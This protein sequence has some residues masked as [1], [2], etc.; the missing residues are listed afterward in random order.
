[1]TETGAEG[2][3]WDLSDLYLSLDD[4]RTELDQM[5]ELASKFGE[6]YRGKIGDSDA[7]GLAFM[8]IELEKIHDRLGRLYTYAYL[9]WSTNTGDTE[10]GAFLQ[11]V[12]EHY[13]R[14][15]Q[16]LL[17]VDIEWGE[18]ESAKAFDLLADP[19]LERFAHYLE[20]VQKQKA[21]QLSEAE[22]RVIAELS[23]NGRSAWNRYFDETL[24]AARFD[25]DGKMLSQQEVLSKLHESDRSLRERA[26]EAFTKGLK[27]D[28]RSLAY[29]FNTILA[30]KASADR[31]RNY[32]SWLSSRNA[33]NEVDDSN[34]EA[35]IKAVTDRYDISIRYY[36]LKSKVLG[37]DKMKDFDRYAPI[38]E[39][40]SKISWREARETV[41]EAYGEFHPELGSIVEE[42]FRENWIDA[43]VV[44]GKR[45]GAFSHGAVPS[46]HPYI[47]MNY[48]GRPRD[49][50]TLA[51][52][53]GHGVHQYLSR[54]QGVFHA[55]T[56]LTTAET[57]S[58]FGE[59]L[60][61][62]SLL[63]KEND[64]KNR[65]AML[66]GKID[67]SM[68]TVFRQV[69]M[70]RFENEVHTARREK[71]ELNPTQ[72][73]DMWMSTQKAMFAD[74]VELTENYRHW[75]S[76][77]PH[78]LHTPG[79]VYAYAFGELLVFGL[80]ERYLKSDGD[81]ENKYVELLSAGGSDYPHELLKPFEVDLKDP[82]FWKE[83]LNAIETWVTEAE[84]LA[85]TF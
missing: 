53:L 52:E 19:Q 26:Q 9:W 47:L 65:L 66:M 77:I 78:F 46:A 74:S 82:E 70:N 81:F 80:Y 2:V 31:L 12:K 67:D 22:E 76:Y 30:D 38:F 27:K 4:A 83:G 55:D 20:L 41:C 75:W 58:V 34:V 6:T 68:A 10:R 7:G 51:H 54:K 71:G 23:V 63:K 14:A 33:S 48:T 8:L 37:L 61:F 69:S 84:Q 18:V 3:H 79:Y 25:L 44:P 17:F 40:E 32:P 36:K 39:S 11:S 1:M 50:Q 56:P 15:A 64:S 42:F 5:V 28:E 43:A 45:G 29:I 21:H 13:S 16:E 85:E 62:Q 60:T 49:V 24:G 73:A 59:M 35:L 72:F 57:A